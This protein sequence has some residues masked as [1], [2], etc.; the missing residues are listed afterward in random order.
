MSCLTLKA[1]TIIR[2][3]QNETIRLTVSEKVKKSPSDPHKT[4]N[5]QKSTQLL[6]KSRKTPKQ[7]HAKSARWGW[8]WMLASCTW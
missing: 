5:E 8:F 7:V 4:N 1:K 2:N 6:K 3:Q